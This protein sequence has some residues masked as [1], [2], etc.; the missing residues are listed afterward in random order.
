MIFS[1]F[2]TTLWDIVR[3]RSASL[4]LSFEELTHALQMSVL[5]VLS[6]IIKS[7]DLLYA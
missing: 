7:L 2:F 6:G 5:G 3:F 1:G 4:I